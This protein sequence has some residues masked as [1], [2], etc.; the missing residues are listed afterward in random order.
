M[1][2]VYEYTQT[3]QPY[4]EAIKRDI[5][6]SS[7]TQAGKDDY[8]ESTW[9]EEAEKLYV[10]FTDA[11]VAGD[12]TIL[13]GII[14]GLPSRPLGKI[15]GEVSSEGQSSTTSDTF[16]QK[17]RLTT[18]NIA[19]GKYR[20][21]WYFEIAS[22][23]SNT[24]VEAKVE[25]DDTHIFAN[26]KAIDRIVSCGGFRYVEVEDG[27]HTIDIDWRVSS[28]NGTAYIRYARLEARVV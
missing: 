6:G 26:P 22:S 14:S 5:D 4:L 9:D 16:E 20:I 10:Q 13:D 21:E 17:L 23:V 27:V 12:K 24:E 15:Y 3:T 8:E 2:Q 25:A 19:A 28:G 7:M 11:L 18:P 1:T